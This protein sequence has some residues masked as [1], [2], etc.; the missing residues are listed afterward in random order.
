MSASILIKLSRFLVVKIIILLDKIFFKQLGQVFDQVLLFEWLI[1]NVA[2]NKTNF[3]K[4]ITNVYQSITNFDQSIKKLI[5]CIFF[6]QPI[7]SMVPFL[8]D[9]LRLS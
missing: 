5:N 1:E 9:W 3:D 8:Y 2:F 7:W 6:D 4:S